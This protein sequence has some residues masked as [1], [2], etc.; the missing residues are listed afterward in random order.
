MHSSTLEAQDLIRLVLSFMPAC[1]GKRF[2]S[3]LSVTATGFRAKNPRCPSFQ[4]FSASLFGYLPGWLPH[5]PGVVLVVQ[6]C[7]PITRRI[8]CTPRTCCTLYYTDSTALCCQQPCLMFE[9]WLTLDFWLTLD[10]WL[11]LDPG[12]SSTQCHCHQVQPKLLLVAAA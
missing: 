2:Q 3:C 9:S 12:H 4:R 10:P 5:H 1:L 6:Q 8:W 7:G 11:M